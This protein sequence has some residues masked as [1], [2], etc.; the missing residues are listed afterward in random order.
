MTGLPPNATVCTLG[1]PSANVELTR[2]RAT[3]QIEIRRAVV[4]VLAAA[5]RGLAQDA[6]A[7]VVRVASLNAG[8][9]VRAVAA[10]RGQLGR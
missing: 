1:V 9:P 8:V 5:D 6:E 10:V 2:T 7:E 3:R 4:P